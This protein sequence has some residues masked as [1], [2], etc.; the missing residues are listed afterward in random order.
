M[1]MAVA[2]LIE[3]GGNVQMQLPIENL[4][5]RW[6]A[7]PDRARLLICASALS[8]LAVLVQ[9][10]IHDR[11]LVPMDEG[12]LATAADWMS[13]GKLLYRDIHTG[14]F[15]GI[16]LL[17]RGLFALFGHDLLVTR[18]AAVAVNAIIMLALWRIA[19]RCVRPHWSALPSLLHASLIVVGFP[20]L[21]MFN[22]STVA[23]CFGLLAL[24]LLLRY[25]E[26]ARRSDAI[27]LGLSTAA[28]ALTKQ[29]FGALTFTA[30]TIALFWNRKRSALAEQSLL[31]AL[32]P[33]AL[34]GGL[35]TLCVIAHFAAV[36]TLPDLI[37]STIVSLGRSQIHDYNNPIPPILGPHPQND[38]VFI[39]LYTPSTMFA[40]LVRGESYAG[41]PITPLVRSAAIRASYGVPLLSLI[42]A[43]LLLWLERRGESTQ[44]SDAARAVTLY[45][46]LF[47][48]GILPSAVWSHLAFVVI[49][50]LLPIAIIVDRIEARLDWH[51]GLRR[52]WRCSIGVL[53]LLCAACV[54]QVDADTVRRNP[55]PLDL[56]RAQLR[57]SKRLAG[58]FLGSLRFIE[59]CSRGD[60]PI[61]VAPDVPA[62]YFLADR[63]SPSP[64]DLV[65]PG[66]VD[67][68]LIARRLEEMHT[69]CVVFN[70]HMYPQFPPFARLFPRLARYLESHYHRTE[71]IRG[72]RDVWWGL[73]RNGDG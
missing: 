44:R 61:F 39:F 55:V 71:E 25:L 12:H 9:L 45:A 24:L 50:I 5:D 43:P 33:I 72:G 30:L 68:A 64:Y 40:S 42:C 60:D 70:P 58:L 38:G 57:V 29:N 31:S 10:P 34:S 19:A 2:R 65:I 46:I 16:Y 35:L 41:V 47:A 18:W 73:V 20:V 32:W 26:S 69:R 59:S 1:R 53:I 22:Y 13:Q 4:R 11:A 67:G 36:G 23:I 66:N 51:A 28:A 17:G 8:L 49:P 62:V 15:P 14:I 63:Q 52:I 3:F 56:D 21:S 6:T 37:D 7:L 54:I 48:P 27:L